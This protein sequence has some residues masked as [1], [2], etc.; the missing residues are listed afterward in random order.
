MK[1]CYLNNQFRDEL[2]FDK[3]DPAKVYKRS[4]IHVGET[5][6]GWHTLPLSYLSGIICYNI[7]TSSK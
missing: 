3:V 5:R 7:L 4:I 2:N 6:N 1:S